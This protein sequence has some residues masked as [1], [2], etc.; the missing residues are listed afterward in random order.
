MMSAI[1]RKTQD[2]DYSLH[3]CHKLPTIRALKNIYIL[4]FTS[5]KTLDNPGKPN[6]VK[7]NYDTRSTFSGDFFLVERERGNVGSYR[8][9]NDFDELNCWVTE[10]VDRVITAPVTDAG[11]GVDAITSHI[12]DVGKLVNREEKKV[13]TF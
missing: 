1:Q 3:T 13:R 5:R 6:E 9:S 12:S 2:Q 7:I 4:T 8:R 11:R 10:V